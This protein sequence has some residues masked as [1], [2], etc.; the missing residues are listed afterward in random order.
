[1]CANV[2]SLSLSVL[3]RAVEVFLL[4]W[5]IVLVDD[6]DDVGDMWLRIIIVLLIHVN[7][8]FLSR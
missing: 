4:F 1:V 6:D 5:E 2:L 8:L 7:A 3:P